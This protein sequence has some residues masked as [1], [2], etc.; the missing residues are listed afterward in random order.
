MS[1]TAGPPGV[2]PAELPSATAKTMD[3]EEPEF[4]PETHRRLAEALQVSLDLGLGLVQSLLRLF[5][6]QVGRLPRDR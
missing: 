1:A 6:V 4:L 2:S 3:G 5:F